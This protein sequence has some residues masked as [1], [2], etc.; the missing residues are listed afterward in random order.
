MATPASDGSL[1][2]VAVYLRRRMRGHKLSASR[3]RAHRPPSPAHAR[4]RARRLCR[5]FDA[6]SAIISG[7]AFAQRA[8]RLPLLFDTT[9]PLLVMPKMPIAATLKMSAYILK[10]R[11]RRSP[12]SREMS[13]IAQSRS[14]SIRVAYAPAATRA[15]H[16]GCRQRAGG[17]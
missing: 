6:V 2:L 12:P 17:A 15:G 11:R 8:Y 4:Y 5:C 3:R 9:P 10:Y 13:P 16:T 7:R 1:K 14:L